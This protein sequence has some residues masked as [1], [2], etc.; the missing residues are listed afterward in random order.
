M[1]PYNC[2]WKLQITS[3][4]PDSLGGAV[5]RYYSFLISAPDGGEWLVGSPCLF[6]RVEK[7]NVLIRQEAVCAPELIWLLQRME[8]YLST[9]GVKTWFLE[10]SVCGLALFLLSCCVFALR[11]NIQTYVLPLFSVRMWNSWSLGA[12]L[13]DVCCPVF[14]F[15]LHF[16]FP[17]LPQLTI[18]TTGGHSRVKCTS[19]SANKVLQP[20]KYSG[21]LNYF[22]PILSL[23]R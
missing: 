23:L 4:T 20:I 8:K 13:Y 3:I 18:Q 21:L 22:L 7:A 15:S 14:V 12:M 10:C 5:A 11:V 17:P 16:Q 9:I 1:S 2:A 6:I 19:P